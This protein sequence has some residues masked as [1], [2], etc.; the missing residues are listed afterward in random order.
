[1][2]DISDTSSF[3]DLRAALEPTADAPIVETP[4]T[5][6]VVIPPVVESEPVVDPVVETV[7]P[8]VDKKPKRF[9]ELTRRAQEAEARTTALAAELAA[10]KS[11]PVTAKPAPVTEPL[12]GKPVLPNADTFTGTWAELET[13]R[14]KYTEDLVAWSV[15]NDRHQRDT[16]KAKADATA[17]ALAVNQTWQQQYDA[18]VEADENAEAAVKKIAPVIGKLG[19]A[20]VV[21]ESEVAMEIILALDADPKRLEKIQGMSIASAAREIGRIED[22]ILAKRTAPVTPAQPKLP[23]PPVAVGG[24]ASGSAVA[25]DL[26]KLDMHDFKAAVRAQLKR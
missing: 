19:I 22:S 15:A 5:T 3:Q 25:V 9:S 18:A 6:E 10:L 11:A 13:A 4:V 14:A 2:A 8:V 17:R 1:M 7:P 21:K 26:N 16:E 23:N 12:Q 24:A 20:D